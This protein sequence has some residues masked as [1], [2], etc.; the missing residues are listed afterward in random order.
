MRAPSEE[1]CVQEGQKWS[2]EMRRHA[3]EERA[4]LLYCAQHYMWC[5]LLHDSPFTARDIS[6]DFCGPG[7]SSL[8]WVCAQMSSVG[9]SGCLG[10]HMLVL[11]IQLLHHRS[12][13]MRHL[14]RA[15]VQCPAVLVAGCCMTNIASVNACSWRARMGSCTSCL[16]YTSPSP[17]DR[18][19]T[20]MPSSA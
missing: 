1:A 12:G 10:A 2:S 13:F 18:T 11:L 20:R 15:L 6:V 14:F 7:V 3:A 4:A 8:D 16:L 5:A 9:C 17:R 19:R